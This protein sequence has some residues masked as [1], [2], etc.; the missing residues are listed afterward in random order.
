LV[1]CPARINCRT[2]LR[3]QKM[4]DVYVGKKVKRLLRDENGFTLS[5][6]IYGIVKEV[7]D[8]RSRKYGGRPRLWRIRFRREDIEQYQLPDYEDLSEHEVRY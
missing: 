1:Q 2:F 3:Q 8:E 4:G 7:L 6:P 5:V